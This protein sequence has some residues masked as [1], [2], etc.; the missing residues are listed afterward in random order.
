VVLSSS[1]LII[2]FSAN[3]I[4]L[5]ALLTENWIWGLIAGLIVGAFLVFNVRSQPA[6]R[7]FKGIEFAFNIIWLGLVYGF[8]DGL[9]LNVMPVLAVWIGF[10]QASIG[11]SWLGTL[12]VG[13]LALLASLLV[14]LTYHLGYSEFRNQSI[15]LVLIGNGLITLAYLISTNLLGAILSHIIMHI[16]ATIQGPKT[17]IQLPPHKK[18]AVPKN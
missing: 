14:T 4:Y 15:G 16:A 13:V 17:T 5:P 1:F 8:I 10:S 18:L 6:T 7:E 11:G 2:F 3:E 12:G 9:F